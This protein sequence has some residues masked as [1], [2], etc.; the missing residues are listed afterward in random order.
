M[1]WEENLTQKS[2]LEPTDFVFLEHDVF[3][4]TQIS[5]MTQIFPSSTSYPQMRPIRSD[6]A[7]LSCDSL[8]YV[9]ATKICEICVTKTI[10][11]RE[12]KYIS[13]NLKVINHS[14]NRRTNIRRIKINQ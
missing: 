9:I 10:I 11:K 2:F 12:I 7:D 4:V 13:V 6:Y 3:K 14:V 1:V 5:E 8:K